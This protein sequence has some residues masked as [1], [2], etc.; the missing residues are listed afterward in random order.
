MGEFAGPSNGKSSGRRGTNRS[1]RGSL[2]H[3]ASVWRR[4]ITPLLNFVSTLLSFLLSLVFLTP[5]PS[6]FKPTGYRS[7][8]VIVPAGAAD[9][10][11][12]DTLFALDKRGEIVGVAPARAGGTGLAIW[13]DDPFGSSPEK[14]GLLS[15]EEFRLWL[16][17][18]GVAT[19]LAFA[20]DPEVTYGETAPFY[21]SEGLF[22][23]SNAQESESTVGFATAGTTVSHGQPLSIPVV[24]SF[25]NDERLAAVQFDLIGGSV[26]QIQTDLPDW[27]LSTNPIEGGTRVVLEGLSAPLSRGDHTL[28]TVEVTASEPVTLHIGAVVGS[29]DNARGTDAALAI[30]QASHAVAL[31]TRG[32]LTG[33]GAVDILDFS[34]TLGLIQEGAYDRRVDLQDFPGGNG[35]VDVRDLVVLGK[36]ILSGT[37]PDGLPV[38]TD[39]SA[40]RSSGDHPVL[41]ISPDGLL[42]SSVPLRALQGR[43]VADS[44]AALADHGLITVDEVT[45]VAFLYYRTSA[46]SFTAPFGYLNG[47]DVSDLIGVT[48]EG[49]RVTLSAARATPTEEGPGGLAFSVYPNPTMGILR[50]E[51]PAG[52][53]SIYDVLGREVRRYDQTGRSG[54]VD[55]RD[56]PAGQYLVRL[57]EQVRVITKL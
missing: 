6:D 29:L 10:V 36:A 26:D 18:D 2:S 37:W 45:G 7:A 56:L 40:R 35:S 44:V 11:E 14:D 25:D 32:D 17:R 43:A 27:N 46:D 48:P 54:E 16:L 53:V 19:P 57:S 20:L 8:T 13:E 12:G 50:I 23:I 42:S 1:G 28:V 47:S 51:G 52:A 39:G 31:T 49:E 15:G 22:V 9:F 30:G 41:S 24:V 5:G 33:D 55:V 34:A 21:T 3:C 38:L 4:S